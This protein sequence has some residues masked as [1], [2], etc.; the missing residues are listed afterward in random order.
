M[1][2]PRLR[3]PNI[4]LLERRRALT[5]LHAFGVADGERAKA[6]AETRPRVEAQSADE[7]STDFRQADL[8]RVRP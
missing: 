7:A 1:V 8:E 5:T 3:N 2:H 4:A 6:E